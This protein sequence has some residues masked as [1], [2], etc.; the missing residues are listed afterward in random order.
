MSGEEEK[1]HMHKYTNGE[2]FEMFCTD[3]WTRILVQN[4]HY[5]GANNFKTSVWYRIE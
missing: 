3:E 2:E 5:E 1:V 4:V